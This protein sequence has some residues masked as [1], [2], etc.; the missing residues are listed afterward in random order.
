MPNISITINK[1]ETGQGQA[2]NMPK[3]E[4]EP[5]KQTTQNSAVNTALIM[6]GRQV[7]TNGVNQVAEL[8]GNYAQADNINTMLGIGADLAMLTVGP[9]GLI[10]VG[11][12]YLTNIANSSIRQYRNRLN[13]DLIKQ[14][15][16]VV[17]T[18]GSRYGK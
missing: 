1:S 17:S 5:G 13:T 6:A 16:G 2:P 9:V 15:A 3:S 8:T 10:A 12:K 18:Q 11:T 14:R 7:L 4:K